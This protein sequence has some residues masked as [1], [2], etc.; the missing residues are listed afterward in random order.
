MTERVSALLLSYCQMLVTGISG[1]ALDQLFS[2]FEFDAVD[3]LGEAFGTV[4]AAL[5][6]GG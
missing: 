5:F 2:V 3:D 6:P 4:E 1:G